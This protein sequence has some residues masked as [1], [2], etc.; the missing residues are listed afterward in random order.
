MSNAAISM[1]SFSHHRISV[2]RIF[3]F[4]HIERS[5]LIWVS[6]KWENF[7]GFVCSSGFQSIFAIAET[8]KSYLN[9]N[10]LT[11]YDKVPLILSTLD[12]VLNTKNRTPYAQSDG[13]WSLFYIWALYLWNRDDSKAKVFR[14]KGKSH[15]IYNEFAVC[16]KR[17]RR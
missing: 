9:A 11:N 15:R 3:L 7:F 5:H 1:K 8:A 2:G 16:I 10:T 4:L 17:N 6:N 14:K 13:G 12:T